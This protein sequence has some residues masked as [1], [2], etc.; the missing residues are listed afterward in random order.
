MNLPKPTLVHKTSY[1]L[2]L[3]LGS[4]VPL[5][6]SIGV[7]RLE[8]QTSQSHAEGLLKELNDNS[9]SYVFVAAHRGGWERDWENQAPENSLV[10]IDKAVRMGFDVFETDLRQS[11]DGHF[12]IMHDATVDRT[13]NGTGRV[14]DLTLSQLKELR[15]KYKNGKLSDESVPTFEEL[16][17]RGKGRILFKIDHKA[18]LEAF[19]DAV[20]LVKEYGMLGH[21]FFLFRRS[22]EFLQISDGLSRFIESGM[23]FHPSLVIFRTRTTEEA[24]AALS[25]FN[26]SII[27]VVF[28]GQEINQQG[29]KT[30][31]VGREA[32]VVVETHSWG[33][34]KEWSELIKAGFRMLHTR[35]PEAMKEFLRSH[36]V[37]Q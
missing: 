7:I 1:V 16:L 4:F 19:P 25:Q 20:R 14:V 10:N 30:L 32:G 13:T 35:E 6:I 29:L 26:P 24:R 27:E 12:V 9:S 5:T 3:A 34:E 36:G 18:P 31:H 15:L 28:E 8:G 2:L 37:L 33:G 22:I 21:V 23:P 11:K 17:G